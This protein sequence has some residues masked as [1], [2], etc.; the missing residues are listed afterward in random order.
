MIN[1]DRYKFTKQ[2]GISYTPPFMQISERD[3]DKYEKY[4]IGISRLD[5]LSYNYYN[6]PKF[7]FL[8]LMANPEYLSEFD[9]PDNAIIRIPYPLN[10]ILG[11]IDED[12]QNELRL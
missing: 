9:I 7:G 5:K 1:Y 3:G 2:E 10:E 11:E 6:D 4:T 8:V 12:I